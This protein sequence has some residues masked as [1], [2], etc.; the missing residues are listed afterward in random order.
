MYYNI[1]FSLKAMKC[2]IQV[3]ENLGVSR[4][5]SQS[6]FIGNPA[7][8]SEGQ[9]YVDESLLICICWYIKKGIDFQKFLNRCLRKHLQVTGVGRIMYMEKLISDSC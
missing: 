8:H 7:C 5:D 1:T 4:Y 2:L 6:S 3:L 9:V